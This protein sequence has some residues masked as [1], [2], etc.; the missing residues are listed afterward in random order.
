MLRKFG[1]IPDVL[2]AIAPRQVLAAAPQGKLPQ[3]L[4]S[5]Q[6]SEK[7]F[8]AEPEVLVKWLKE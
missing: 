8:T 7:R 1:D 3:S 5:V 4:A 6:I 2:A